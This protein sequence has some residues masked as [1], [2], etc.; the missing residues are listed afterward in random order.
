M[1]P[2]PPSSRPPALPTDVATL[3]DGCNPEQLEAIT[4]PHH[5]LRILAG[6]GS[7]KTRVLTRRIAHRVITDDVDPRHVLA[8]T[9]T[10][11]A[12]GELNSRLRALGLRDAVAAGTFHG[13]AYAQLRSRWADRNIKPPALLDRKL[14]FLRRMLPPG[15]DH[16]AAL[17]L[18]GEIEWA[19][20]RAITP[21]RYERAAGAAGRKTS[22][23]PA[24]VATLFER[25]EEDKKQRRMVDFDDLLSLCRRAISTDAD[26]A[27]TQRWRF[28]HLFVDE[29]QD[30]NPLQFS[31]LGAWLGERDDL[32][33]VGDPNQAIYAWNGADADYLVSFERHFAGAR[34]VELRHNYRSSPEILGAAAAGL[35]PGRL[36]GHRLIAARPSG[37]APALRSFRTDKDEA[38]GIARAVRDARAPGHRWS[39]QAVLVRTNAQIPLIDEALRAA[40]IPCRTRGGG[41]LARPEV[42]AALSG[43]EAGRAPLATALV[44]L[45]LASEPVDEQPAAEADRRAN[46]AALVRLGHDLLAVDPSATAGSFVE[47]ARAAASA[48]QL[49]S[50]ADAVDVLTFH[51]AK[52][53][54]WPVVHL[55]GVE[56]GYVPIGHA[57]R[58]AEIGE[59]RRLFYVAC[60]RAEQQLRITW[61]DQRT[62]GTRTMN[63]SRSA[64]LDDVELVNASPKL[65]A[66]RA[67]AGRAGVRPG[68][69]PA[70]RRPARRD[71]DDPLLD[72]LKRWRSTVAKAANVPAYVVFADATLEAVAARRPRARGDLAGLTGI[73]PVKLERYGEALLQVVRDEVAAGAGTADT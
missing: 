52:G 43:L 56:D 48:D 7:G 41:L 50:W 4:T 20:A 35:G 21:E 36:A 8:L 17:D 25:Y 34:T 6:A 33:V 73:G 15:S 37:P 3:L 67:A 62:F 58:E 12:A 9:F 29:F 71:V 14:G 55:A 53:L 23:T 40:G 2:P 65:L 44:D 57:K 60:T 26:F 5:P 22:L 30:V 38:V 69:R 11:K 32:C 16:T 45:E 13:I 51:A 28:R 24:R 46:V 54:E 64:W 27:A 42:K 18:A 49:D 31:L 10:R 47:W 19:K 66:A 61:A 59:E 39:E 1:A 70:A 68:A 72:A 63:R